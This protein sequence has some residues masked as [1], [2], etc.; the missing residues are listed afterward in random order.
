M[1]AT[2]RKHPLSPHPAPQ[3]GDFDEVRLTTQAITKSCPRYH[4][5][6]HIGYRQPPSAVKVEFS[7]VA[8]L[9]KVRELGGT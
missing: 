6:F 2:G 8:P 7:R 9:A 5:Y 3:S 1:A 4:T